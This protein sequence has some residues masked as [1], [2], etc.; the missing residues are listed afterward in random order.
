MCGRSS[1]TKSEKELEDR[2]NATFYSEDLERYNPLPNFNV[3]P[4]H[5]MP[6]ITNKDPDHFKPL[7]WGLIP[8]WA[9]DIK[10]GYRMINAR[11]ETVLDKP[12]FKYAMGK[13]RCL[14][15][16]DGY[17]EWVKTKDGKIPYRITLKDGALF[18]VAGLWETWKSPDGEW[19]N[20]FTV[21]T[22][23]PSPAIAFIHDRMPAMLQPSHEQAWLDM[24][25]P[26]KE[27]LDI[28]LP[29]PDESLK[30]QTVSKKVNHV[31]QNEPSLI[32][33]V[34]YPELKQVGLF[35]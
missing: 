23:T 4:T 26:A 15:P 28:I 11:V 19:I 29:Y 8:F 22:T 35:D 27:V 5:V 18:S 32:E 14:V 3:A 1:L 21:L 31:A 34:S 9:K 13:R 2:F 33:P 10:I 24:D 12:A 7:R 6:V 17:Y 16:M 30:A 25:L 20:S